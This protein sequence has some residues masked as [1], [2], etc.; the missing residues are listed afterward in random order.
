M[1]P[2]NICWLIAGSS[3]HHQCWLNISESCLQPLQ[4]VSV[5]I[6]LIKWR[7]FY[8][9]CGFI[10][11]L[12]VKV[13]GISKRLLVGMCVQGVPLKVGVW[14]KKRQTFLFCKG[15]WSYVLIKKSKLV[16]L[17]V[18]LLLLSSSCRAFFK[19]TSLKMTFI[20]FHSLRVI[21]QNED[22]GQREKFTLKHLEYRCT[23]PYL[24][25]LY[26]F[27]FLDPETCTL[28]IIRSSVSGRNWVQY[29]NRSIYVHSFSKH[30]LSRLSLVLEI[31]RWI[32]RNSLPSVTSRCT[33]GTSVMGV[34]VREGFLNE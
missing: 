5:D 9:C 7:S 26:L 25:L 6:I 20:D 27:C 31:L 28:G 12:S 30:L 32:R 17:E 1:L 8:F 11:F 18:P 10:F 23:P 3:S 16:E 33:W 29:T 14:K 4:K 19:P 13:L 2:V 21:L 34:G 22:E 24:V 15:F